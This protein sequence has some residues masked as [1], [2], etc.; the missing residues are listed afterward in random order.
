MISVNS[1][2]TEFKSEIITFFFSFL[3][4]IKVETDS[5]LLLNNSLTL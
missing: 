3:L 4:K 5:E 2:C 1:P